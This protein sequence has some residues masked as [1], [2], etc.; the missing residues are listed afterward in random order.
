M[1]IELTAADKRTFFL[2]LHPH[3]SQALAEAAGF[4]PASEDVGDIELIDT[5]AKWSVLSASNCL[6][7]AL[8]CSDWISKFLT[9]RNGLDD[10]YTA[11]YRVIFYGFSAALLSLLLDKEVMDIVGDPYEICE[12]VA[13]RL[14]L[15][16]DEFK[17]ALDQLILQEE[18]GYDE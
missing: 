16:P 18:E 15:P 12:D 4:H 6:D 3:E 1:T 10:R 5:V 13:E 17:R 14:G 2:M 8:L 9:D 11:H 7:I